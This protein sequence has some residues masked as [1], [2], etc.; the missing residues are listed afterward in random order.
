[1]PDPRSEIADAQTESLRRQAVHFEALGS[2]VYARLAEQLALDP[3]PAAAILD[4]DAGW[5]IALRLFGG[6]HHLVLAGTAPAALSGRWDDFT[7]ALR[8]HDAELRT[9]MAVQGVQTNEVQRCI[10]LLPALLTVATETGMRLELLELGPSAGLNLE[11]DRYRYHYAEGA[12]GNPAS[13][14]V[15]E[16]NEEE[17]GRV[18][19][20]LL[21][22]PLTIRGRRGVDL[23]P[24]DATTEEGLMLLRSFIW[25]GREDRRERLDAAVAVLRAARERPELIRGDYVDLLAGLLHGRPRDAVTVVFQTASTGYLPAA[26]RARLAAV[27]DEAADDGRPLAWIS[28]RNHDERQ[29]ER[30]DAWELELRVWP[31]PLRHVAHLDFHG[32]RL[33]WLG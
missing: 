17:G 4:G 15:L 24:V 8:D 22:E 32:N 9:W 18:P 20:S 31:G 21:S 29:G 25:P 12:W 30:E 28:T 10:G 2:P 16:A 14:L 3:V 1:M 11:L 23:A 33:G 7:A 19:A 5:D 26:A 6:V 13:P 27:L